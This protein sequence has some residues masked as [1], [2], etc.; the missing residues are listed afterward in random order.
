MAFYYY[1]ECKNCRLTVKAADVFYACHSKTLP[2]Q[3]TNDTTKSIFFLFLFFFCSNQLICAHE[4]LF[5]DLVIRY[6]NWRPSQLVAPLQISSPGV[7]VRRCWE[8]IYTATSRSFVKVERF[9][10]AS[11]ELCVP[12]E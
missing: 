12:K 5:A 7:V 1:P 3:I 11:N 8:M 10:A 4:Y 9:G 2:K 6:A